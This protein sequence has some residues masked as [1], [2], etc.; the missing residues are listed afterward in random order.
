M[1]TGCNTNVLYR[2]KQFHVQTEDSG[3]ANPHIISHVYHGGTI[4]A[5]EKSE[6]GDR[7]DSEE[8]DIKVRA[9]IELQHKAMLKRLTSGELDELI[10]ERIGGL[11]PV[12]KPPPPR[13]AT[14]DVAEPPP[15]AAG[16]SAARAAD[17]SVAKRA[18]LAAEDSVAK[19]AA[20]IAEASAAGRAAIASDAASSTANAADTAGATASGAD[21]ASSTA[22]AADTAGATA[23]GADSTGS[24]TA[25]A[26]TDPSVD[27]QRPVADT[28]PLLD[29]KT[30]PGFGTRS[31]SE[32][33]LDEVIL[34][35]LVDKARGR[36]AGNKQP[37]ARRQ[38]KKG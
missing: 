5:S 34:E 4:I 35:Y 11:T 16:R 20:R 22:N 14:S 31:D 25:G 6:Y 32:K 13:A 10:E 18:A 24:I 3:R 27:A 9:K 28:E 15:R 8:I 23:S 29:G 19:R 30:T 12:E 36:S 26:A 37:P 33:P 7:V 1:I 21:A 17:A 2:G 38:R